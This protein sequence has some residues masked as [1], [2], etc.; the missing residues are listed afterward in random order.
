ML[1]GDYVFGGYGREDVVL[2]C[3]I[4]FVVVGCVVV[5]ICMRYRCVWWYGGC[6]W[7]F[8]EVLFLIFGLGLI[9]C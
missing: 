7:M 3:V 4:W 6:S 1:E 2:F 5:L 9:C 8:F